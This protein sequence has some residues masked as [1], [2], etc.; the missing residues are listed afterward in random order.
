MEKQKARRYKLGWSSP[1]RGYK[2]PPSL[3]KPHPSYAAKIYIS[4]T[5]GVYRYCLVSSRNTRSSQDS[6]FHQNWDASDRRCQ[7]SRPRHGWLSKR[8]EAICF[9][10]Q[11][12]QISHGGGHTRSQLTSAAKPGISLAS[13]S[14]SSDMMEWASSSSRMSSGG[15]AK[16]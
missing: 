2:N 13:S 14:R 8:E 12:R 15:I 5:C 10:S 16:E 1:G 11:R 6:T 4:Q 9:R 7:H 3:M